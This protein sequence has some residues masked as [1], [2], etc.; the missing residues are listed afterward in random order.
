MPLD[1]P[2]ESVTTLNKE[3]QNFSL[4]YGVTFLKALLKNKR[5][6]LGEDLYGTLHDITSNV[7]KMYYQSNDEDQRINALDVLIF[8]N[9][10]EKLAHLLENV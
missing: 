7:A 5:I 4:N 10:T 1:M 3:S 9:S 6:D 2:D 8:I